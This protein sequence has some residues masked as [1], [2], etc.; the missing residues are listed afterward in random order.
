MNTQKNPIAIF[1]KKL[2]HD[3]EEQKLSQQELQHI[4]DFYN[5]FSNSTP[6]SDEEFLKFYTMG[7]YIYKT[8][9][10]K[11]KNQENQNDFT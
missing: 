2:A 11:P 7:W 6:T 3:I 4:Q 8:I 10:E 5:S 1:L 9:E